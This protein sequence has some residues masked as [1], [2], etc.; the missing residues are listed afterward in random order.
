MTAETL[1]IRQAMRGDLAELDALYAR[2]YPAILKRDYAPSVLVTALP[3]LARAQPRLIASGSFHVAL[4]D[5]RIVGGAGWSWSGPQGGAG[6][7]N[8]AHV[9]HVV[10]DPGQLRKGIGR[11]LMGRVLDEA[12]AGGAQLM[13]CQSTLTAVPFYAALGFVEIGPIRVTLRP[14]IEFP[15]VHMQ[16][17]M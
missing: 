7:L 9:R 10:T 15:A 12:A 14:G 3:L 8:M 2:A 1:T 13:D 4:M 6:P 16:R 11:V 17:R 5:G